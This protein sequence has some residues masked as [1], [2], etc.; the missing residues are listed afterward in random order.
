[1]GKHVS[2]NSFSDSTVTS[3]HGGSSLLLALHSHSHSVFSTLQVSS[4]TWLQFIVSPN[5]RRHPSGSPSDLITGLPSWR[6]GKVQAHVKA[7]R[8]D[9]SLKNSPQNVLTLLPSTLCILEVDEQLKSHPTGSGYLFT[10]V[11]VVVCKLTLTWHINCVMRPHWNRQSP[12]ILYGTLWDPPQDTVGPS[13]CP[14]GTYHFFTHLPDFLSPASAP[15][16]LRGSWQ[17]AS[18]RKLTLLGSTHTPM[19]YCLGKITPQGTVF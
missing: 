1:M 18:A 16:N 3:L 15:L 11:Y 13:P 6:R 9:S 12:N 4:E 2:C 17:K 19:T 10:S 8:A 14:L 5:F 7:H